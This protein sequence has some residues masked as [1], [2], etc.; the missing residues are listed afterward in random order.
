MMTTDETRTAWQLA[1]LAGCADPDTHESAGADFLRRVERDTLEALDDRG[2]DD[3]GDLAH[4]VAD[5]AVPIYTHERWQVFVDL[6]AYQQDVSDLAGG[7]EDLTTLAGYALYEIARNLFYALA[8][9]RDHGCQCT[10]DPDTG[11]LHDSD[12][13]ACGHS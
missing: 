9:E 8:N 4:E 12:G 1:R 6:A 11:E 7:S 5:S 10:P 2:D 3:R 13:F